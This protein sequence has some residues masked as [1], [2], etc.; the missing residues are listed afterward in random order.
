METRKQ[1]DGIKLPTKLLHC[2]NINCKSSECKHKIDS[3]YNDIVN[4]LSSASNRVFQHDAKN[5]KRRGAVS[6]WNVY[7]KESHILARE[8]VQK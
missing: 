8:A 5:I 7:V 6:G 3:F 1:S 4:S 2:A